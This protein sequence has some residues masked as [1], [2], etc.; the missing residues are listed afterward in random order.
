M[1]PPSEGK[2]AATDPHAEPLNLDALTLPCLAPDRNQVLQELIDV[3]GRQEAQQVLGVGDRVMEQVSANQELQQAPTA[4]AHHIY[5]GVLFDA[6]AAETLTSSQ[7]QRAAERVL[8]FSG[9][10]GVTGFTDRIPAYRCAMDVRLPT[11]GKLS[12]FW[13]HRLA[14]PVSER[15]RD[16]WVVDCRSAAYATAFR[17][18]PHKTVAVNS[19]TEKDGRRTVVT[20]SAKAA[21]GTLTGMML[22]ADSPPKTLDD[23]AHL[24]SRRW[25]VE[26]RAA[27]A[28]KPHQLDLITSEATSE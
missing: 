6:L 17:P 19:F 10:F 16:Q 14:A 7:R 25:K 18:D 12:A 23:V 27:T 20:H 4:P 3:S 8:I 15:I 1:L 24:A 13:R 28:K 11:L 22:R 2:T 26:V 21:R 5:S 9:L